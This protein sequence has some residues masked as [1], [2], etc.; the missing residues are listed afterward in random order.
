MQVQFTLFHISY[1]FFYFWE[2]ATHVKETQKILLGPSDKPPNVIVLT[3]N[4][5]P[6]P[7]I[8]KSPELTLMFATDEFRTDTGFKLYFESGIFK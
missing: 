7:L 4:S 5:I 1:D 6:Q 3:G 2:T 8:T